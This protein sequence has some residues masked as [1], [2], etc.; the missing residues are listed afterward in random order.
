MRQT[1]GQEHAPY[2]RHRI[3]RLQDLPHHRRS[4]R[5]VHLDGRGHEGFEQWQCIRTAMDR[6]QCSGEFPGR[7]QRHIFFGREGLRARSI[8]QHFPWRQRRWYRNVRARRI[9]QMKSCRL[10]SQCLL[11]ASVCAWRLAQ[12]FYVDMH[13]QTFLAT[14]ALLLTARFWCSSKCSS[15]LATVF[16]CGN[17]DA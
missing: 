2:R 6:Q 7:L 3:R 1:P 5:R 10:S 12:S 8:H 9:G 4:R 11:A 13:I 16:L 15:A 17:N 14:P